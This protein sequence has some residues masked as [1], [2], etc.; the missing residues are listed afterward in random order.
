MKKNIVILLTSLFLMSVTAVF[1]QPYYAQGQYPYQEFKAYYEENVKPVLLEQQQKFM[2][3]LTSEEKEQLAQIK[4]QWKTT[5]ETM[6]GKVP[7]AQ[8]K[9][10]QKAHFQAFNSQVEKIVDAHPAEKE[11]YIKVMS[12]KK[13]QWKK[14]IQAI[15]A[16]YNFDENKKMGFYNRVDDPAFILVWDPDKMYAKAAARKGKMTKSKITQPGITVFPQPAS[17]TATLSESPAC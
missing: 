6:K 3:V 14:D 15:R 13:E 11:E 7:P 10:T 2:S 5:H 17:A 12:A 8:R 16:K 1:A 4:E 9:D